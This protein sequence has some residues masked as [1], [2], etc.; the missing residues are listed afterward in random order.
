MTRQQKVSQLKR[1]MKRDI[2][3]E[4]WAMSDNCYT[5]D[6][7]RRL[8]GST[9]TYEHL[10]QVANELELYDIPKDEVESLIEHFKKYTLRKLKGHDKL[11]ELE[12]IMESAREMYL[13]NTGYH[14][15][16]IMREKY[17]V[18]EYL[19]VSGYKPKFRHDYLK[20]LK[21]L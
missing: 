19:E 17:A 18:Q 4:V 21:G 2:S 20:F 8:F 10:E 1:I 7:M 3:E 12:E 9:D 11:M 6:I 13:F 14:A 16:T 5:D 15:D